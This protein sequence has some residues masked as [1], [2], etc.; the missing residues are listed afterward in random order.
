MFQQIYPWG[1]IHPRLR[2]TTIAKKIM[3]T[4]PNSRGVLQFPRAVFAAAP[5]MVCAK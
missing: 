1:L 5:V 2:R 4:L 3:R